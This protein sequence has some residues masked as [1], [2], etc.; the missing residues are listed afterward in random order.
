MKTKKIPVVSHKVAKQQTIKDI[1]LDGL[2]KGHPL[3]TMMTKVKKTGRKPISKS[4]QWYVNTVKNSINKNFNSGKEMKTFIKRY[5][6]KD[7]Q[8]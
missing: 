4:I 8:E 7:K 2:L 5:I 3:A 6:K 1:V